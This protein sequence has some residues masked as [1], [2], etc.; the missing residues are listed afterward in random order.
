MPISPFI[1]GYK[2][3]ERGTAMLPRLNWRS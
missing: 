1:G 3:R 2:M